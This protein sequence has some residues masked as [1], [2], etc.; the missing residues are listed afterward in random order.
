MQ[1]FNSIPVMQRI[2]DTI[3]DAVFLQDNAAAHTVSVFTGW[4][5]KH[6]IQVDEHPLYLPDLNPIEHVWA[7]LKQQLHKQHSDISDTP[8]GPDAVR[9]RLIEVPPKVWNSLPEQLF[10]N[11]YAR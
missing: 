5:E 6:N 11:L 8:G 4:Y 9:I 2:N 3:G 10:D 7:I 1:E